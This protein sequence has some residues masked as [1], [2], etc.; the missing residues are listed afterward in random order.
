M[1]FAYG[2]VTPYGRPFQA[3]RLSIICRLGVLQPQPKLVWALPVSLAATQGID[4]SFSSSGYCDVSVPRVYRR[5]S[6]EFT[7]RQHII[8]CWV[9]P[10]GNLRFNAYLQLPEAYRCWFRPSSALSA[11]AS[12]VRPS[13]LNRNEFVSV[14]PKTAQRVFVCT[15]FNFSSRF[16]TL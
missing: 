5:V 11:K 6:Y 10:F 3:V 14:P 13:L 1:P 2:T 7:D 4:F 8:M 9:P 15:L 12:T 16:S